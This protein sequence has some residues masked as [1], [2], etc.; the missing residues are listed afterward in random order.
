[1]S[2][3]IV[4]VLGLASALACGPEGPRP[5]RLNTQCEPSQTCVLEDGATVGTC[6]EA[7]LD[8]DGG[9]P[10]DDLPADAGPEVDGGDVVEHDA[11]APDD[12]GESDAGPPPM[13]ANHVATGGGFA[14][15][16][17]FAEE[18]F[19]W[20]YNSN[21]QLGNT[22]MATNVAYLPTRVP[23]LSDV[24]KLAAARDHAC[25]I[26]TYNGSDGVFCW[27][28]SASGELGLAPGQAAGVPHRVNLDDDVHAAA[29]DLQTGTSDTCVL[30]SDDE[31]W[32]W[33]PSVPGYTAG[34]PLR[35]DAFTGALNLRVSDGALCATLQTGVRCLDQPGVVGDLCTSGVGALECD[36][37]DDA[38]AFTFTAQN[39]CRLD[40]GDSAGALRCG[41]ANDFG[42]VIPSAPTNAGYTFTPVE[43]GY[44][45]STIALGDQHACALGVD[46]KV[47]C[48]GRNLWFATGQAEDVGEPCSSGAV[49]HEALVVPDLPA[50]TD[51][52]TFGFFTCA[53][54]G[55]GA[56]W[57]WGALG[58]DV[59]FAPQR[60]ALPE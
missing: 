57:C 34:F 12:A 6:A 17:T 23:L 15:A 19:C 22:T 29:V 60:Y 50:V 38:V 16:V 24:R 56:V 30:T 2:S 13:S 36:A 32:C 18:V 40:G 27:G 21:G 11:G 31:V 9:T 59:R 44:S 45:T 3:S 20:G 55:D 51:L 58:S 53:V 42:V 28:T 43:P 14:C 47:R 35:I 33:G 25:A 48:W 54:A 41:G 46:S 1:M 52:D 5:C 39:A 8:D 26:G 4:A 7:L 37:L 10:I 49:C